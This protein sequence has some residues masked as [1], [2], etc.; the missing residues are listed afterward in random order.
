MIEETPEEKIPKR[1]S[2]QKERS[3]PKARE[4]IETQETKVPRKEVIEH[5]TKIHKEYT[6]DYEEQP[7]ER[8]SVD[9]RVTTYTDRLDGVHKVIRAN[10][11]SIPVSSLS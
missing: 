5:E 6:T 8:R 1:E 4:S 9:E 3:K 2:P 10:S 7:W 11:S